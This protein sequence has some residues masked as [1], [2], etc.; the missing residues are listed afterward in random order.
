MGQVVN[1]YEGMLAAPLRKEDAAWA[2]VVAQQLGVTLGS[3]LDG[4]ST[5]VTWAVSQLGLESFEGLQPAVARISELAKLS[6]QG[7]NNNFCLTLPTVAAYR[8][9]YTMRYTRY[10]LVAILAL[11]VL[12]WAWNARFESPFRVIRSDVTNFVA[13][14]VRSR[15]RPAVLVADVPIKLVPVGDSGG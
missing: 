5:Y 7:N 3:I 2:A 4:D 13:S 15:V 1:T 14:L 11:F 6:V 12:L 10:L 9:S 8:A